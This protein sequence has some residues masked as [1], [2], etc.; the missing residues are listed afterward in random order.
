[1]DPY[2][3]AYAD[4]CSRTPG[5]PEHLLLWL[6]VHAMHHEM[7][8]SP[9]H[10]LMQPVAPMMSMCSSIMHNMSSAIFQHV[11]STCLPAIFQHVMSAWA[12]RLVF[13]QGLCS[14]PICLR[15]LQD[16][17]LGDCTAACRRS[18][19]HGESGNCSPGHQGE[20]CP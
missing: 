20:P 16:G 17:D 11:I 1:M 9:V 5:K 19:P 10:L 4:D 13:L 3:S 8:Q 6:L 7:L 15:T 12:L 14:Q 2:K 18:G